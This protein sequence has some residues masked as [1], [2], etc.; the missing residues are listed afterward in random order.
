MNAPLLV[1]RPQLLTDIAYDRLREGIVAGDLKL[2]EQVSEAQLAQRMGISKTP[3]REALVRLKMEGLVEIVPQKGTFVFKLTPEQVGQL[4]RYR[5]MIETQALREAAAVQPRE[6]ISRL[7]AH[8]AEMVV[9]EKAGDTSK[10]SR[11]DM[12]FHY[13]FLACCTNPYL[14]AAYEL[15]RYQLIALRHRSPISNM[16]DSHQILIDLLEKG[17]IEAAARQLHEH[18]LE[19]EARYSAACSGA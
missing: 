9:Q 4:C 1:E 12:N 14:R 3:V 18:V 2:G 11:I 5:A 8:V 7:S 15:I 10:L 13:E 17:D 16:V 6:L 19:N